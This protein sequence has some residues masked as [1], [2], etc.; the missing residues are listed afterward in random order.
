MFLNVVVSFVPDSNVVAPTSLMKGMGEN[1]TRLPLSF[2]DLFKR[3][4]T[5]IARKPYE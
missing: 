4:I 2:I 3:G 5:D 1:N